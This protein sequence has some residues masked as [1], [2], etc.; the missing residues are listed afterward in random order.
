VIFRDNAPRY[1]AKNI[2]VIPCGENSKR[3]LPTNWSAYSLRMP[4][5]DTRKRWMHEWP[6]GN[7]G[8][9]LGEQA[10]L[11]ALDLDTDDPK[12]MAILDAVLPPS[13][14]VRRGK[15]GYVRLYKYTGQRTFRIMTLE[16]KPVV[17]LLAKG[18]QVILP[19]SIHPDTMRP[20]EANCEL[21]DVLDSIGSLPKEI[22]TILRESLVEAGISLS[23]K[24]STKI[25]EYVAAGARDSSMTAMA[26]LLA[27]AVI[28]GERKLTEAFEEMA[29]WLSSFVEKVAGDNV[30][31][32][33]AENKIIYFL[34]RDV[35]EGKKTL[36]K[37]W[38]Q[39]LSDEVAEKLR[40]EF[41]D[42]GE[43]WALSQFMEEITTQFEAVKAGDPERIRIIDS[44]LMK[45]GRQE[46]LSSL[47]E[48][49]ILQFMVT[50]NNRGLSISSMRRRLTELRKGEVLGLD[51]SEIAR[52]LKKEME[53]YGDVRVEADT[54]YQWGG[55]C[56]RVL[57]RHEI[58]R[59]LSED[60]GHLPGA[61]KSSD[62][63]GI[64][65]VLANIVGRDLA[66]VD[67]EGINFA[68]GY[69]SV[70]GELLPHDPK[71]GAKYVLPYRYL[72]EKEG[73]CPRFLSF[74]HDCWGHEND[75]SELVQGLREAIAATAFGVAYRYSRAFCFYGIAHSGKSTLMKIVSGL[76]PD[77]ALC[78]VRPHTW[79]ER[80]S[81]NQ[82]IGKLMNLCG[83]LSED[84]NIA[85]DRFKGIVEGEPMP[86]E[87]KGRDGFMYRPLLS[88]WF[89]TNHLPKT[90]DS[91]SGFN[92]RWLF[93][94]FNRATPLE[95]KVNSLEIDIL[96]QEREAIIAWAVPAI[97]TLRQNQDYTMGAS[98]HDAVREMANSNNSVR[99]FFA[100]G[101]VTVTPQQSTKNRTSE[102]DLYTR[103]YGFCRSMANARPVSLK[104]FRMMAQ[105]LQRELGFEIHKTCLNG[106]DD[107]WY[108]FVTLVA[109]P[110]AA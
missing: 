29:T 30:D 26:G 49:T 69:L 13:P 41:G 2:P 6:A 83:E 47:D 1:W 85:G 82:M 56:W 7:I 72:K 70:D 24:G 55:A 105:E 88:H 3:A 43:E 104:K 61:R 62:H 75:F 91:S 57:E 54:F 94:P 71:F 4:D 21:L 98:H 92:R 36:P 22:E 18:A 51:H 11:V 25:T 52:E 79:G 64:M 46:N 80:F 99:Y 50:A 28:R 107:A 59:T 66:S 12:V 68:N 38:D 39:G 10:G 17:E 97:T 58:L 109:E 74:L 103:Y 48:E 65:A 8:L 102:R 32:A 95:R 31:P 42:E 60:F 93:W 20:Y 44:V 87:Y 81:T 110:K 106:Q 9:V 27:R 34:K 89:A 67:L 84:Q 90:R 96:A 78:S 5:E 86:M 16:G 76:F 53:K 37:G 73:A 77:E 23:T 101:G 108:Q 15:K 35:L 19:P 33:T 45:M 100:A 63:K 14:W 40:K